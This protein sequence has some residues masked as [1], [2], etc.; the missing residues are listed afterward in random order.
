MCKLDMC[1]LASVYVYVCVYAYMCICVCV[2]LYIRICV[3]LCVN[4]Y[5]C[6]CVKMTNEIEYPFDYNV[7]KY[8]GISYYREARDFGMRK[9]CNKR[10]RRI[11]HT[12]RTR[13]LMNIEKRNL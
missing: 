5:M 13:P 10:E 3:S 2:Y 1:R 12:C 8:V 11:V 9:G 6:I 7:S 4:V